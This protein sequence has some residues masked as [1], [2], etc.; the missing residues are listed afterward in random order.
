MKPT[1]TQS[2]KDVVISLIYSHFDSL[3]TS[4]LDYREFLLNRIIRLQPQP[5]NPETGYSMR[6]Q[7]IHQHIHISLQPKFWRRYQYFL[8]NEYSNGNHSVEVMSLLDKLINKSY[9]KV[10]K[11]YERVN[12]HYECIS[13]YKQSLELA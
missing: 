7:F 8:L 10:G 2:N 12:K 9:K 3:P 6:Y 4:E 11:L 13:Q 5:K 1:Q